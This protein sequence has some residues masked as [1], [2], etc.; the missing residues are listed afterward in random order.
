[1][2]AYEKQRTKHMVRMRNLI[3][4]SLHSCTNLIPYSLLC[5]YHSSCLVAWSCRQSWRSWI[6]LK[7]DLKLRSSSLQ[8]SNKFIETMMTVFTSYMHL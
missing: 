8:V 2:K 1:M 4:Y 3:P 7:T 6:K 5:Y